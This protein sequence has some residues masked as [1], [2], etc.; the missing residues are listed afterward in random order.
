MQKGK[1]VVNCARFAVLAYPRLLTSTIVEAKE[2]GMWG[3]RPS[4]IEVQSVDMSPDRMVR[5]AAAA[6]AAA[7]AA[8]T[9]RA[10][11]AAAN[12]QRA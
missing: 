1:P 7:A 10:A 9:S 12:H 6:A 4:T 3:K 2:E 8:S 5:K 11:S